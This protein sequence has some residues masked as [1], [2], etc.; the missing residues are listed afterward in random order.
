MKGRKKELDPAEARR[1]EEKAVLRRAGREALIATYYAPCKKV[2]ID[3]E[4]WHQIPLQ[5]IQE[6]CGV[7]YPF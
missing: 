3:V 2:A 4:D 5:Q 6:R 1:R 7:Y